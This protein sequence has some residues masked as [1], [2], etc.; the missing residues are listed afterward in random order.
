MTHWNNTSPTDPQRAFERRDGARVEMDLSR[1]GNPRWFAKL[2]GE[3]LCGKLFA[4]S[5]TSDGALRS[6]K[7]AEAAMKALDKEKPL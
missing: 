3:Y 7:S 6:F 4:H 2:P 5:E 1:S